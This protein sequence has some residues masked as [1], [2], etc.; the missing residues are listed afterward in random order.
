VRPLVLEGGPEPALRER[1]APAQQ[2]QD[3]FPHL[4]HDWDVPAF[5]R[6]QR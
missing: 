1:A 6:K 5:Q 3:S 2:Q 4:E